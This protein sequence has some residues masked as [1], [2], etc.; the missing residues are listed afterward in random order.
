[1]RGELITL[2]YRAAARVADALPERSLPAVGRIA[3][4]IGGWPQ[5]ANRKMAA[6]H[7]AR[8]RGYDDPHAVDEVF[9]AYGR[10]WLEMLRLPDEVRRGTI[11]EN[12]DAVG[13]EYLLAAFE[14]GNGVAL[15]L[16]HLG[17]WEWAAAWM[18]G[19]G[20]H[21]LA[22]VERLEPPELR[23]WFEAQRESYGLEIVALGDE[24]MSKRVLKALRDNRIVCLLSDRDLTGDGV[25]VEFF[26]ERTTLPAGPAT[27]AL[28]TGAALLP[29]AV[30]FTEGRGHRG[31]V[32][33]PI[34]T[35]RGG[36]LREDVA[37]IT[38]C[39][40]RQFEVLI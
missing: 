19:L 10:Y 23:E 37:R 27:L 5:R 29:V 1:M 2:A 6:K 11:M 14:R 30:Y 22:V 8:V 12:F 4:R 7:Q 32:E 17:G 35:E 34:P 31:V 21:M 20:Y 3:G 25:E 39:L 9:E 28:R 15:A 36:R 13:Y 40:A 38:Q 24:D 33:A 18:A 26:G 16:P